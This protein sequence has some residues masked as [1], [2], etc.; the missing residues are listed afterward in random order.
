[1]ASHC[2]VGAYI[3]Q[4][5]MLEMRESRMPLSGVCTSQVHTPTSVLTIVGQLSTKLQQQAPCESTL[6]HVLAGTPSN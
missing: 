4:H 6:A 3:W 1:M 5:L 2:Q